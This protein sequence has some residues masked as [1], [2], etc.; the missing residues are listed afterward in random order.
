M[1]WWQPLPDDKEPTLTINLSKFGPLDIAAVRIWW[2][3]VGFNIKGGVFPG[4]FGYRVEAR[5]T[6]GEWKCVL[7]RSDNTVDMNIEYHPIEITPANDVRLVITKK[8][9]GIEPGVVN[10]TVFSV[11]P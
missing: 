10:F 4:P 11:R 7:D 6:D 2:R 3:D 9:D 1:T 8:P 5:L